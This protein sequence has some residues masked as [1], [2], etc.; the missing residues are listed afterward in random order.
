MFLMTQLP[1]LP[2]KGPKNERLDR[3]GKIAVAEGAVENDGRSFDEIAQERRSIE[4]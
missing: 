4:R 2:I 3:G 1:L